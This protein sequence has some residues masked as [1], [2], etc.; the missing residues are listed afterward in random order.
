L[1]FQVANSKLYGPKDLFEDIAFDEVRR[2]VLKVVEYIRAHGPFEPH[3]LGEKELEYT[4][5]PQIIE[6]LKNRFKKIG[7][8]KKASLSQEKE[9]ALQEMD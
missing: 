8:K 9:E 1:G 5:I 4:T 3:R 2:K 7:I 6:R